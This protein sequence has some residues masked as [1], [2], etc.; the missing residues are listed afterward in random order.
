MELPHI[1]VVNLQAS[2]AARLK[3]WHCEKGLVSHLL[4]SEK[5]VQEKNLMLMI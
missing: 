3:S 1:E 2:K 5:A 4:T